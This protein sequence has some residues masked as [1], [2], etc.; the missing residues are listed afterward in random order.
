MKE[1]F[2]IIWLVLFIAWLLWLVIYPIYSK[3]KAKCFDWSIYAL[4]MSTLA[5]IINVFNLIIQ[6]GN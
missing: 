1:L 5:V 3:I 2:M 4:V 6:M